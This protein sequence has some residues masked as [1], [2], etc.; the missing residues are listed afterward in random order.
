MLTGLNARGRFKIMNAKKVFKKYE[1]LK[2]EFLKC[3]INESEK[4]HGGRIRTSKGKN[5]KEERM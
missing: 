4:K 3:N 2:T 1:F 5:E